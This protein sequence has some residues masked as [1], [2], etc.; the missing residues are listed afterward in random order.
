[1]LIKSQANFPCNYFQKN[2]NY[3]IRV[4]QFSQTDVWTTC[5]IN[6]ALCVASRGKNQKRT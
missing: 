6:T 4:H 1:M 3:T 5:R 2:Q